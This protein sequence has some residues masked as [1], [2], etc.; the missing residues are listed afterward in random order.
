M[1]DLKALGREIEHLA[2]IMD[3]TELSNE[4]MK[5]MAAMGVWVQN[6]VEKLDTDEQKA[7][8]AMATLDAAEKLREATTKVHEACIEIKSSFM[9]LEIAKGGKADA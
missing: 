8:I 6:N 5:Y 4:A 7:L 3:V 2:E 9:A 1:A